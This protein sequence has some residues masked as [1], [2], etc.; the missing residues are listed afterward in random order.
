MT[1]TDALSLRKAEEC[2]RLV[3]DV[4]RNYAVFVL[5]SGGIIETWNQG[6]EAL[7]GYSTEEALG[8]HVSLLYLPE[9]ARE[10]KPDRDLA[11]GLSPGF[12]EENWRLCKDGSRFW[13]K[14][15]INPLRDERGELLGFTQLV[16]DGTER[17]QS[18]DLLRALRKETDDL[19]HV[20]DVSMI[21]SVADAQGIITDVNAAFEKI[22][23]YS[24]EE[25]V[26]KT[27]QMMNSGHHPKVFFEEMW[28]TI[29]DNRVW[30][31]E[32][33]NRAKDGSFYWV[34][35]T[36]VP[37]LADR[38]GSEP[39]QYVSVWRDVTAVKQ[40]AEAFQLSIQEVNDIRYALDQSTI[41]AFTDVKGDITYVNEAFCRISHYSREELL[42]QNHRI[43]NS[44]YH[45]REFFVEMWK[46]ISQG[47][48]WRNEIRNRTKEG[49]YYW[50][51][52]TIVPQMDPVT[53]RP[54]CYI[55][56]RHDI[57]AQK[58]AEAEVKELNRELEARVQERTA[59]LQT[60]NKELE[61]FSYSVSHDLRTP[62]RSIDG[63]SNLVLQTKADQL[64]E[65]GKEYLGLVRAA[66][67]RMAE[68]IDDLLDL[69]RLSRTEVRKE[70]LDLSKMANDIIALL[71]RQQPDRTL[72]VFIA[73][74]LYA[75]G[76][77]NLMRVALQN[78]LE[79]AWKFT[80]E[81][82]KGTIEFAST[83]KN[84]KVVYYIRDNGA[85]FDMAYSGKLFG[86][87]QR[88]HDE[89]EF[90]GTG[91]GLATVLRIIHRHGGHIWAEG[92]VGKG[93]TFYFTVN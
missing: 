49:T 10:G 25:L 36:I 1:A 68:L 78:L 28:R 69:S 41:L 56:I 53:G 58:T 61:A 14:I 73:E 72:N 85:G 66:A 7:F 30:R 60:I 44:H 63:F 80:S 6:A 26:G 62:L 50:V 87:F 33:R 21:V 5:S 2:Y 89:E 27:F 54:R 16:C 82:E 75:E 91:V 64:D 43:I 20:L 39:F 18:G 71:Q 51:D 67:Q 93:A 19:W 47:R 4:L 35:A 29:L 83:Q 46:T 79:N 17:K 32:I 88:L 38:G 81:T 40:M 57:T 55:S 42:G 77:P 76:D 12:E 15:A 3:S 70:S 45:P 31:G 11:R 34:D 24:K 90:P 59:Q 23:K 22:S 52:T 48:V 9:H 13:A 37:L 74:G 86:A 8:R 84:G 92:E 65:E